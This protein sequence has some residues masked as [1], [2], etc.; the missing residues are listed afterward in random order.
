MAVMPIHSPGLQHPIHVAFMT[1]SAHM[2]NNFVISSCLQGLPD[3]S[4][5]I[6]QNFIPGNSLPL[7][8]ASLA[9]PFHRIKNAIRI[10]DLVDRCRTFR[11][12]PAAAAGMIRIAFELPDL[13]GLLVYVTEKTTTGLAVETDR[14]HNHVMLCSACG[15]AR[16]FVFYQVIP[17]FGRRIVRQFSRFS[18]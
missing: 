16:W 4:G 10:V 2:I 17:L 18:Q 13:H 6:I 12:I 7:T 5:K 8:F 14:W 1:R 11:A 9:G 3:A 15:P